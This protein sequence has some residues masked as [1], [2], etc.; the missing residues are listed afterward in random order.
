LEITNAISENDSEPGV[1]TAGQNGGGERESDM[2]RGG[3]DTL[4]VLRDG[5]LELNLECQET[6]VG[7]GPSGPATEDRGVESEH[8]GAVTVDVDVFLIEEETG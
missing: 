3:F 1:S 6:E 5:I 8:E 4:K 7:H 2:G